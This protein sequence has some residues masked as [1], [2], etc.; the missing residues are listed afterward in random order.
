MKILKIA[1]SALIFGALAV[2]PA[3]ADRY[4]STFSPD[5]TSLYAVVTAEPEQVCLGQSTQ[6][7]VVAT[8]GSSNYTFTWTS[9]PPGFNASSTDALVTPSVTTVYTVVVNDGLTSTTA[10]VTVTVNP[11]PRVNITPLFNSNIR[12]TATGLIGVCVFDSVT[13]DAGNPGS[14]YS[15]NNGST[16]Q[17]ITAQSSGIS[18]DL[19][20]YSVTVTD[21]STGCSNSNSLSVEFT[22]TDC[23]YGIG[24]KPASRIMEVYPNPSSSGIFNLKVGSAMKSAEVKVFSSTGI[25]IKTEATRAFSNSGTY[26]LDL[27][28]QPEGIYFLRCACMNQKLIILR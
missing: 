24:D 15:W 25:L 20:D 16:D 1:L 8:G 2:S 26:T 6:L 27:S 19:Q 13:L 14:I 5:G 4:F 11:L 7:L 9:D 23:T 17:M 18:Y 10:S 12:E 28:G 22:F 21:P 3:F